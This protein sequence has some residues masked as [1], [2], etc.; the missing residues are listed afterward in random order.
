M[1][2]Q[3]PEERPGLHLVL[4]RAVEP[5][6][7]RSRYGAPGEASEGD[8]N[9]GERGGSGARTQVAS[10]SAIAESRCMDTHS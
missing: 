7:P 4:K 2:P 10:L 9:S 8:R 3:N 1:G 6:P 5:R